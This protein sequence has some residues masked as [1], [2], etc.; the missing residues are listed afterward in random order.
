MRKKKKEKIDRI[1]K[2]KY[3]NARAIKRSIESSV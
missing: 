2:F 1:E 3:I